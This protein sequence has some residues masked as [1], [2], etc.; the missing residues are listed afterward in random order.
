MRCHLKVDRHSETGRGERPTAGSPLCAWGREEQGELG[1]PPSPG[2]GVAHLS[3]RSTCPHL[4]GSC[5]RED[6]NNLRSDDLRR[7][8]V[9]VQMD[10]RP[11]R[12]ETRLN[13][14]DAE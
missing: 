9:Q 13:L 2:R 12:I 4:P 7:E 14:H 3:S 10:L 5:I 6:I 8:T 1:E 11:E